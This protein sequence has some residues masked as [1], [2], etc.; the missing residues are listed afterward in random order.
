MLL[1]RAAEKAPFGA[2]HCQVPA[3]APDETATGRPAAAT[4]VAVKPAVGVKRPHSRTAAAD[5]PG[6]AA[7]YA[8][9]QESSNLGTS[10]SLRWLAPST[11]PIAGDRF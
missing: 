4:M 1:K 9:L 5:T 7:F 2:G 11:I 3:L 8:P 10:F 6:P